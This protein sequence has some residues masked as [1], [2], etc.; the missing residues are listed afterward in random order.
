M[1]TTLLLLRHGEHERGPGVLCGRLAGVGLSARGLAQAQALGAR[2]NDEGARALYTSPVERCTQTAAVIGH[3]CGL[4]P[5]VHGHAT[6]IDFGAWS[7]RSFTDL[8]GDPRWREWNTMRAEGRAPDG[9]AMQEVAQRVARLLEWSCGRHANGAILLVTHAEVIRTAV[10][11]A[12]G[13]PLQGYERLEIDP[14]SISTMIFR[15]GRWRIAG[16]NDV[17]HLHAVRAVEAA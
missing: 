12:L 5:E 6:E 8:E 2:L 16:L 14:A 7:G 15:E 17:G 13:L 1:S 4:R 9:E 3:A 11:L 10:L